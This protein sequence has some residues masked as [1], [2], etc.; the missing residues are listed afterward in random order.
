MNLDYIFILN[1]VTH[2]VHTYAHIMRS[3]IEK[4][5]H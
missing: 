5:K 1:T 4:N 3:Q 2:N